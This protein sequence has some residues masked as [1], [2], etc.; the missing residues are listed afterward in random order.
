MIGFCLLLIF[1]GFMGLIGFSAYLYFLG[2]IEVFPWTWLLGFVVLTFGLLIPKSP[3]SLQKV[4]RFFKRSVK[5]INAINFISLISIL[6]IIIGTAALILVLSVFNGFENLIGDL[7]NSFNP[8]VKVMPAEGKVFTVDSTTL[9]KIESLESVALVSQTIEEIAAFEYDKAQDFGILKGVDENFRKVTEIDST[10]RHGEFLLKDEERFFSVVGL[11]MAYKLGVNVEDIFEPLNIY[12]PKRKA[13]TSAFD[14]PFYKKITYPTAVFSIQQEIDGQFVLVDLAF[15]QKL[16]SYK[17]GEISALECKLVEGADLETA[18]AEIGAIMGPGFK[19]KDRYQQDEAFYKLM[20]MEKWVT[21]VILSFTLVLIMFNLLGSLLMMVVE[22]KKD[23][24]ILRSMGASSDLIRNIFFT[25][26]M[27]IT[28]VGLFIGFALAILIFLAQQTFG[29]IELQ[30]DGAYVV[31]AYP[32]GLRFFDFVFVFLTVL[33]L[34]AL[35]SWMPARRAAKMENL[36]IE[37]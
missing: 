30:G 27:M 2:E 18:K 29:I 12:M 17:K 19:I 34:G 11:G 14:K 31:D 5:H 36:T 24:S 21:Y 28:I 8:E 10:V 13:S 25:E 23:I 3:I 33:G 37:D 15:A 16:L 20:N 4:G 9:A 22:K 32:V 7:I 26:G 35:F 1:L 6:G